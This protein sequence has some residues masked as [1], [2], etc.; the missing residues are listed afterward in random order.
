VTGQRLI[1]EKLTGQKPFEPDPSLIPPNP[2][3]M[4]AVPKKNC[5][6]HNNFLYQRP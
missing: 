1:A 6:L 5:H 3:I 4:A 2:T